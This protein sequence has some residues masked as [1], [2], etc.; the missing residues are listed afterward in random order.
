MPECDWCGRPTNGGAH[1]PY[2]SRRCKEEGAASVRQTREREAEAAAVRRVVKLK[3]ATTGQA[4]LVG[5]GVVTGLVGGF[6]CFADAL[7]LLEGTW[8]K[9]VPWGIFGWLVTKGSAFVTFSGFCLALGDWFR[10]Q[11]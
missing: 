11:N 8:G 7:W 9:D 10:R 2:C 4:V 3:A 6:L 5:G 1:S